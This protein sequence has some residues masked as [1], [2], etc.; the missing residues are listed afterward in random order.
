MEAGYRLGSDRGSPNHGSTLFSNRTMA[1]IRSPVEGQDEQAGPVADAGW[2]A[3]IG[4]ERRLAVG[5]CSGLA[6]RASST[7]AP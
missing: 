3:Q 1:Q 5:S 2:R 6:T 4:A 7:R